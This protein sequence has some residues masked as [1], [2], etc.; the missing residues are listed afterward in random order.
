V[1]EL[2]SHTERNDRLEKEVQG[3]LTMNKGLEKRTQS[4]EKDLNEFRTNM[5]TASSS[6]D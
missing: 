6:V 2:R 5:V 3:L 4:L 1:S